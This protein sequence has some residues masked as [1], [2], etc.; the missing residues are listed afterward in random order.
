[1]L[2]CLLFALPSGAQQAIPFDP[3]SFDK[4]TGTY[5]LAPGSVVTV[6]RGA[7][8]YFI[9]LTR[10]PAQEIFPETTTR[11]F[12]KG[13]ALKVQFELDAAGEAGGLVIHQGGRLRCR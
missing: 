3:P 7:D 9:K 4:F 1:M 11:F 13:L 12:A 10:Q 5:Q 2:V 8:H 6:S